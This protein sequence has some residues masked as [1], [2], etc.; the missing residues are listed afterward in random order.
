[1]AGLMSSCDFRGK[2]I[3]EAR[4]WFLIMGVLAGLFVLVALLTCRI[5]GVPV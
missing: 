3:V 2:E 5:T 4:H 1:M